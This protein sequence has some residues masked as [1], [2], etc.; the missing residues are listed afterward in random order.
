M[1][2][3]T[4][5]QERIPFRVDDTYVTAIRWNQTLCIILKI[6]CLIR[7]YKVAYYILAHTSM[8]GIVYHD[9]EKHII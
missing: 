6:A 5:V 7:F 8:H 1:D 4:G 2:S 3:F 9:I